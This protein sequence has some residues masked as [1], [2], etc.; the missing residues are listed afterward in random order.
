MTN[1]PEK[2]LD[3]TGHARRVFLEPGQLAVP[4]HRI[5]LGGDDGERRTQ[6]VRGICREL[7][8]DGEAT[9]FGN[10]LRTTRPTFA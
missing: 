8:L 3:E 10:P 2:L 5:E 4:F 6:L 7:A 9:L 1:D